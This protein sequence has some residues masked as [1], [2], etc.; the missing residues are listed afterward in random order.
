M[1]VPGAKRT[2]SDARLLRNV[3]K[4]VCEEMLEVM[5]EE[6][7][8]LAHGR[9]GPALAT[10][11][12]VLWGMGWAGLG[13]TGWGHACRARLLLHSATAVD[14]IKNISAQ[15]W[16]DLCTQL[17]A[18]ASGAVIFS[19]AI[20][21][22]REAP[23]LGLRLSPSRTIHHPPRI[24][25]NCVRISMATWANPFCL[26]SCLPAS[27]PPAGERRCACAWRAIQCNIRLS[28]VG[29]L[30]WGCIPAVA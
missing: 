11:N 4:D 21:S 19:G 26:S 10:G 15:W 24:C 28:F 9:R 2:R 1:S 8:L 7:C 20:H 23:R 5:L 12:R 14:D 6:A 18:D 3:R 29:N 13:W 25:C 27:A 30:T 17:Y 16:A 22:K